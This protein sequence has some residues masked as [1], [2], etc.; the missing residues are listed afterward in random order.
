M[1]LITNAILVRYGEV[2]LRG[3]NRAE[4]LH[5][6]RNN[7]S[8]RLRSVGIGWPVSLGDGECRIKVRESD[9]ET[10]GRAL[11][12]V[13]EVPGVV[14]Y[15]P[16]H[17]IAPREAGLRDGAPNWPLI[18][19]T[20][21]SW[22]ASSFE[23]NLSFRV[24]ARRAL[25]SFP[26]PSPEIEARL[27]EVIRRRTAWQK[28]R[29]K[30]PDRTFYVDFRADG[31]YLYGERMQGAGGLP[32][33]SAGRAVALLSGGIDSPVAAY[34]MARRG[35]SVDFVHFSAEFPRPQTA[36]AEKVA[37]LAALLSRYTLRSR[38]YV[39]P[40]GHFEVAMLGGRTRYEL[41]HFRTFMARVAERVAAEREAPVLVSGDCLGQ[42]ASQTLE[43]MASVS[44]AVGIPI[45]RPLVGFDKQEIIALARSIGTYELSI[46]PDKDC[47]ALIGG[48]P[49]TR[50]FVDVLD[51]EQE[52][53]I[54]DYEELVRRSLEDAV[55]VDC[56]CGRVTAV[57]ALR[58][59]HSGLLASAPR[60]GCP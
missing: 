2:S 36:G 27:G 21:V 40:Y 30:R 18:E 14:W 8:R 54:E 38:L 11:A 39:V 10:I 34:L 25:K 59:T 37:R 41:Q 5:W 4:F 43:N 17:R 19:E 51:R 16:A 28:V 6:L 60:G 32:V 29:L 49:K 9:G 56:R 55:V 23:E 50:S 7:L 33:G 20:V 52:R 22:A 1:S 13:S 57:R 26:V 42:V 12:A 35:C 53:L 44:R 15:A 3:K 58:E 46:G 45:L 31:L 48:H 24:R 47:C